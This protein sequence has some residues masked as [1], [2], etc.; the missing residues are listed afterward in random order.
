LGGSSRTFLLGSVLKKRVDT[1]H[2]DDDDDDE[3]NLKEERA[4]R[5]REGERRTPRRLP[6]GARW[7]ASRLAAAAAMDDEACDVMMRT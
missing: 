2:D 4:A 5:G 1:E 7:Q 3:P 6:V